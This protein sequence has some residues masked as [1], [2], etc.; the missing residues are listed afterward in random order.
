M[1]HQE[2]ELGRVEEMV[3]ER[4]LNGKYMSPWRSRFWR[5]DLWDPMDDTTITGDVWHFTTGMM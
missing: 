2:G 1:E 3:R 4:S 5:V